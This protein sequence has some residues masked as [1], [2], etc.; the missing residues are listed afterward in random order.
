MRGRSSGIAGQQLGVGSGVATGRGRAAKGG[1][2]VQALRRS[3]ARPAPAADRA[4]QQQRRWEEG[5]RAFQ[6]GQFAEAIRAFAGC[7]RAEAAA[8]IAEARL[9]LAL[10]TPREAVAH[11]TEAVRCSPEDARLHHHLGIALWRARQPA[12][13]LASARRAEALAPADPRYQAQRALL[14]TLCGQAPASHWRAALLAAAGGDDLPAAAPGAPAWAQGLLGALR[15]VA[16]AAWPEALAAAT[17]GLGQP[18]IPPEAVEALRYCAAVAAAGSGQWAG[19]LASTP[20]AGPF[21]AR[22]AALRREAAGHLLLA[23]D[24]DAEARD[25]AASVLAA[26][27]GIPGAVRERID[28]ALG[29]RRAELGHWSEAIQRWSPASKRQDLLQPLALAHERNRNISGAQPLWERLAA[30]ARR[31]DAPAG[32]PPALV[33]RC[34]YEHLAELAQR[35]GDAEG[36]LRWAEEALALTEAPSADQRF[37]VTRH[38][39][40]A[41]PEPAAAW[42]RAAALLEQLAAEDPLNGAVWARLAHVRRG[43]GQL[44]LT[45]EAAQRWYALAP[46]DRTRAVRLT[47][48]F[49]HAILE[50]LQAL[51]LERAT[52]LA[53]E[54]RGLAGSPAA[55]K[56]E[57][58]ADVLAELALAVL[59]RARPGGR[60]GRAIVRWDQGLELEE[61]APTAACLLRGLLL[62]CGGHTR[63]ASAMFM[64][65]VETAEDRSSAE[66]AR[67]LRWSAMAFGWARQLRQPPAAEAWAGSQDSRQMRQWLVDAA[68]TD[69]TA[70]GLPAAPACLAAEPDVAQDY[71]R[72]SALR[73]PPWP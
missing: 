17:A 31:G 27:G 19:L 23:P 40:E 70:P 18:G 49:G 43:Q 21:A 73:P 45:L 32:L 2:D 57:S 42:A 69:P 8:A 1:I 38:I 11:L 9:R 10:A 59:R 47:D 14:A 15:A 46:G 36:A 4:G 62:L 55:T 56:T 60:P 35:T 29:L 37:A 13:A 50:A 65:A 33:A 26:A 51:D 20:P 58:W 39:L 12:A 53:E 66:E 68:K 30:R 25:A 72:W 24:G 34:V 6:R 7:E 44:A 64:S 61:D 52:R 67:C 48:D 28:V 5:R 3:G 71:L 54:V 22:C 41:H 63:R 16:A